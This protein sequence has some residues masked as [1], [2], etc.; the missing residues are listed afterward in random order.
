MDINIFCFSGDCIMLVPLLATKLPVKSWFG[1]F[2]LIFVFLHNL[3]ILLG[4]SAEGPRPYG[5]GGGDPWRFGRPQLPRGRPQPPRR[6]QWRCGPLP[7]RPR[8]RPTGEMSMRMPMWKGLG[9]C[10]FSC[11]YIYMYVS[12]YAC[13]YACMHVCMYACM[14]VCR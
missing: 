9:V 11:I 5:D 6:Q 2:C 4:L 13:T 12:M 1:F 8:G 10:M 3:I 7:S 14:H